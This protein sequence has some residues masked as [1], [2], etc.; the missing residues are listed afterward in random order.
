MTSFDQYHS[1]L[2]RSEDRTQKTLFQKFLAQEVGIPV[3]RHSGGPLEQMLVATISTII[4]PFSPFFLHRLLSHSR[5]ALIKRV[6]QQKITG[7]PKNQ[8]INPFPYPVNQLGVPGYH[9]VFFSEGTVAGSTPLQAVR[10]CKQR[11]RSLCATTLVFLGVKAPLE[12]AHV[13]NNK[14][15]K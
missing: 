8:G 2:S 9:F 12:L 15:K 4:F 11:A 10:L 5:N 3:F 13:K 6:I 14:M 7:S 1:K